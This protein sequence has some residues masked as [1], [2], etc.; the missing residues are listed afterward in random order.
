MLGTVHGTVQG[1]VQ[2]TIVYRKV[3]TA[4][5]QKPGVLESRILARCNIC[6]QFW[7]YLQQCCVVDVDADPDPD[8][9]IRIMKNGSRSV[10]GSG[11]R[12]W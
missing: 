2:G 3:G 1:T 8:P 5:L 9:R 11:S 7:S 6:R 12:S 10:A 4:G